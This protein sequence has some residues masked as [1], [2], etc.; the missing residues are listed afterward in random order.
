MKAAEKLF[1]GRT[2][3]NDVFLTKKDSKVQKLVQKGYITAREKEE[4]E[5]HW[6]VRISFF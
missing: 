1:Y 5:I 4:I 2:K 3:D 6:P